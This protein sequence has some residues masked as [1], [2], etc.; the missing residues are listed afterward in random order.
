MVPFVIEKADLVLPQGVLKA[1]RL[2]VEDGLIARIGRFS[3]LGVKKRIQA[4]GCLILPGII[5][6][7]SDA[8]EKDL[9]PR[10]NT[11]FPVDLVVL[12][13]DK[14]LAACG[15]CTIFHSVSFA[16][17]E[18]GI[19]SNAVADHIIREIDRLRH[20]LRVRTRIH[21]RYELS[22]SEALPYLHRLIIEGKIHLLSLMNHYPG[23][24]QFQDL[25]AYEKY[26]GA[27]YQKSPDEIQDILKRKTVAI[28]NLQER[29]ASV[30]E[31]IRPHRIPLAS[32]DDD[33]KEK[34]FWLKEMGVTISDFPVTLEA[35]LTAADL[36]IYVCLGA[37]NAL[38]G[39]SQSNNLSARE[40]IRE[41]ACHILCSDYSPMTMIHAV[42]TLIQS[43]FISL[44]DAV[45]LVTL[46]PAKAVGIDNW[47]GSLEEGKAA[48]FLIVDSSKGRPQILKTFVGGCE[49]FSTCLK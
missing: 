33:S 25:Q 19:R 5:D 15:I 26:Y 24:G 13:M 2:L 47:T 27:V 1:S 21:A 46:H 10:P 14:K 12:E 4:E 18:I 35:A 22:D 29:A 48:D 39:R 3:S 8:L 45:R 28:R 43:G 34:M 7:H 11:F 41:K 23:Q 40:A 9:E 49:V 6:L 36:N 37:P 17:G 42:F 16:E 20:R 38:R 30:I 44:P 32:H 31:W